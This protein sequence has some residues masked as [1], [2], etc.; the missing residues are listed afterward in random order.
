MYMRSDD[1]KENTEENNT[2]I[3]LLPLEISGLERISA[4]RNHRKWLYFGRTWKKYC[5]GIDIIRY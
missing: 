1:Y 4:M 2:L 3:S 5:H